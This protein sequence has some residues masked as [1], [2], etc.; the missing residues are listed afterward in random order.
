MFL[1][2]V[3][4]ALVRKLEPS[5]NMTPRDLAAMCVMWVAIA[6]P[7]DPTEHKDLELDLAGVP[8]ELAEETANGMAEFIIETL[9]NGRPLEN[10]LGTPT[11]EQ[12]AAPEVD[13]GQVDDA[14]LERLL[15]DAGL[16]R[17]FGVQID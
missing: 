7:N 12:L 5:S 1:S 2:D 16:E 17:L 10:C 8:D 4:R 6:A 9:Q 3:T 11:D 14:R 15:E 13:D